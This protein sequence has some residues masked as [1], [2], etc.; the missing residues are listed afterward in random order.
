M[1][2][3]PNEIIGQTK[4]L[5]IIG[6]KISRV[7]SDGT[8]L[9]LMLSGPSGVGKTLLANEIFKAMELP[10]VERAGSSLNKS[11]EWSGFVR[12]ILTNIYS[13]RGCGIFIDESQGMKDVTQQA[14]LKPM[15]EAR[16]MVGNSGHANNLPNVH[17]ILG[18]TE[19]N[20]HRKDIRSRLKE[21]SLTLLSPEDSA[22]LALQMAAKRVDKQL[23]L[24]LAK[25]SGGNPRD[26]RNL[27]DDAIDRGP[28]ATKSD[29]LEQAQ[30]DHALVSIRGREIL[31]TIWNQN[32]MGTSLADVVAITGY[33]Y[34]LVSEEIAK[35][36]AMGMV[37]KA[38]GIGISLTGKAISYMMEEQ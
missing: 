4:P 12:E 17:W 30:L 20:K 1:E 15:E 10:M 18:T 14:L 11:R 16:I 26:L 9:K 24:M 31:S 22:R 8:T 25:A 29:V 34:S 27:I 19:P 21:V 7:K 28:M 36:R 35:L 5:E 2:W 33:G 32:M 37:D 23:L 3:P 6:Y 13:H 38:T